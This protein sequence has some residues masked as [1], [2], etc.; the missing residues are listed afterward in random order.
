MYRRA[1]TLAAHRFD[2]G[3]ASLVGEPVSLDEAP[4]PS[5]TVGSPTVSASP[6]GVLA[7]MSGG[8]PNT[9][10]YWLDRAGQPIAEVAAPPGRELELALSPDGSRVATV[11]YTNGVA[12]I[13][14]LDL[15]RGTLSRFTF[16]GSDHAGPLWSPDGRHLAYE[17]DRTGRW[18]LY[19][20]PIAGSGEEVTLFQSDAQFKHPS[21]WSQDGRYIL[22]EQLDETTGWDV[23]MLDVKTHEAAPLLQSR[24]NERSGALSPDGR[25]LSYTSDES[26]RDEVF[27]RSHPAGNHKLQITNGGG[28]VG[29]WRDDGLELLFAAGT[30][31]TVQTLSMRRGSELPVERPRTLFQLE[32]GLTAFAPAADF[33]R[34][35]LA[36]PPD[37]FGTRSLHVV[38]DWTA[39]LTGR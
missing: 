3:K 22:F 23:W 6:A 27:L 21:D 31:F 14:I 19:M 13:W 38:L 26:G 25:W 2:A 24:F 5:L 39:E 36:T 32:P 29:G 9:R 15:D 16:G 10:L 35:L 34:F 4:L 1:E 18:D 17:S 37:P 8:Q 33:E 11:R 28:F 30:G 7:Y 20:K 12:D